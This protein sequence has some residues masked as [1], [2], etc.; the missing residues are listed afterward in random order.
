MEQFRQGDVFLEKVSDL[1]AEI[2][3]T[4]QPTNNQSELLIKGE[5]RNHGHFIEGDVE[6]F[7]VEPTENQN[8]IITHYLNVKTESLLKHLKI[9]TKDFTKEH[10]EIKLKPGVYNVV[11]Q[12]EYN[13]YQKAINIVK[14]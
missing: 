4:I 2:K 12:R 13:A 9:D 8:E 1:P 10:S 7:S 5:S 6:T 3:Q 14:D 11:R